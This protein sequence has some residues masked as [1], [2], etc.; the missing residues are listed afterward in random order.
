[1]IMICANCT[2][3]VDF[4]TN[5]SSNSLTLLS[6]ILAFI[7]YLIQ[8]RSE[9]Q[10]IIENNINELVA[11]V[12]KFRTINENAL[13]DR[14]PS[15]T[16][17][18]VKQKY[19]ILKED[20]RSASTEFLKEFNTLQF[21]IYEGLL[22]HLV[23]F[24]T[25]NYYDDYIYEINIDKFQLW[26]KEVFPYLSDAEITRKEINPII[27]DNM[28]NW[29]QRI[30]SNNNIDNIKNFY[31]SYWGTLRDIRTKSIKINNEMKKYYEIWFNSVF[32]SPISKLFIIL[33]L[34]LFLVFGLIVP[35]YMIQPNKFKVLL[36]SDVFYIIVIFLFISIIL[37][38]IAY[39]KRYKYN[40]NPNDAQQNRYS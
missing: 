30:N 15:T 5:L 10:E 23:P 25:Q 6:I 40:M 16:I 11:I 35:I 38:C 14:L 39:I 8:R 33:S 3:Y 36:C 27:M 28:I 7:I 2:E 21:Q 9:R 12:Y 26:M 13:V 32:D 1:M 17:E 20:G 19:S 29:F 31:E 18:D 34:F 24:Q 4:Y 37:F 22:K